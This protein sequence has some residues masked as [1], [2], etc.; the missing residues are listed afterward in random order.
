MRPIVL[1]DIDTPDVWA[2]LRWMTAR[3]SDWVLIGGLMV[4]TFDLE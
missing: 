3:S 2:L 4:A 1:D